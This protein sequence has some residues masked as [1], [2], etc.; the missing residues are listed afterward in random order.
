MGEG[1]TVRRTGG[2]FG[3]SRTAT[4]GR[5]R[6]STAAPAR[7]Q[8]RDVAVFAEAEEH[9]IETRFVSEETA[10]FSLVEPRR[11]VGHVSKT[12]DCSWLLQQSNRAFDSRV[13]QMHVALRF[14]Q[15]PMACQFLNGLLQVRPSS[16]DAN[17]RCV[18]G[19]ALPSSPDRRDAFAT[20]LC[21]TRFVSRRPS[22][23][24][25][26]IVECRGFT[27]WK[28]VFFRVVRRVLG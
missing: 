28:P 6:S 25:S 27:E 5:S 7:E 12:R 26:T 23:S 3:L 1:V 16:R 10:R 21:T 14:L 17:R 24:Q 2:G 22:S 4:T 15:V 8:R 19:Y 13:T 20:S 11:V 18:S 9:P